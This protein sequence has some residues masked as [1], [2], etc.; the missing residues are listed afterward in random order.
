MVALQT[1]VWWVL[2]PL[3]FTLGLPHPLSTLVNV[4]LAPLLGAT[5]IPLAMIAWLSGTFPVLWGHVGDPVFLGVVFDFA[6]VKTAK[7]IAWLSSVLPEAT[8]KIGNTS[9]LLF[10]FELSTVLLISLFSGAVALLIRTRR[11]GRAEAL[12]QTPWQAWAMIAVAIIASVVLH[13]Q[14]GAYLQTR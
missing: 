11:Q 12:A 14:I 6:W 7:L 2:L 4:V 8:P 1:A 10:G 5:L 3:L 9:P 13:G